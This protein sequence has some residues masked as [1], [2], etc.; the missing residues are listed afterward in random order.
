MTDL[1]ALLA[2]R[3]TL[4]NRLKTI[5]AAL[6]DL[7]VDISK[8][9]EAIKLAHTQRTEAIQKGKRMYALFLEVKSELTRYDVMIRQCIDAIADQHIGNREGAY[10]LTGGMVIART[11]VNGFYYTAFIELL[12]SS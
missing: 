6:G 11:R 7:R 8:I 4:E 10:L 9:D 12:D 3:E 2:D 1:G 5:E